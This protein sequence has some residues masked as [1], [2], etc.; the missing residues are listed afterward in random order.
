[1]T[2]RFRHLM[3]RLFPSSATDEHVRQILIQKLYAQPG[4]MLVGAVCGVLT[5]W[6][7]AAEDEAHRL[8]VSAT[9]LTAIATIRVVMAYGLPRWK[10][11]DKRVLERLFE[12]GAFTYAAMIG[13]VAAESV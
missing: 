1:M 11:F 9:F 13:I 8:S 10:A 6:G 2:A 4:V 3:Q 5:A 12:F 7:A